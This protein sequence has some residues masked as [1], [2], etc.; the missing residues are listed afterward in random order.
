M[1]DSDLQLLLLNM[2]IMHAAW[3]AK[4]VTGW[5]LGYSQFYSH[6]LRVVSAIMQ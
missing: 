2:A 1:C 6:I 3:Q 4:P 5:S